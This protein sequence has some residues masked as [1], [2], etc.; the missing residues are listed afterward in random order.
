[1]TSIIFYFD[2]KTYKRFG[3]KGQKNTLR[4]TPKDGRHSHS[5]NLVSILQPF[6]VKNPKCPIFVNGVCRAKKSCFCLF[7]LCS[8]E[9]DKKIVKST[10]FCEKQVNF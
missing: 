1:M 3:D 10:I 4:L 5:V 2:C 6:L 7:P 9:E 8:D